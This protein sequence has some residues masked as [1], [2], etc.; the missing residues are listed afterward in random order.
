[1]LLNTP[2]PEHEKP[3]NIAV[4]GGG[5]SG[6]GAA[7][8]LSTSHKITLF[9]ARNRLGGHARTIMAGHGEKFPVDTGFMVFNYRNY[10]NLNGLFDQLEIPVKPTNMSFAVSLDNGRFEYGLHNPKRL[11]ANPVNAINPKFWK[12]IS[13]ILKFNKYGG[14]FKN[15]ENLTIGALI[16]LLGLSRVFKDRCLLYTSP[17][18]RD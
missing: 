18:P 10:P 15:D 3:L 9:E 2:S 13:D 17:S 4:I 12:M 8:S 11:F 5:I 6:L 1:M 7:Y 14:Q 16:E